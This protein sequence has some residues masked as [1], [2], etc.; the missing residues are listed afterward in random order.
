MWLRDVGPHGFVSRL[1]MDGAAVWLLDLTVVILSTE[2]WP[3]DVQTRPG[4]HP[5]GN[6]VRMR[7]RASEFWFDIAPEGLATFLLTTRS[8]PCAFFGYRQRAGHSVV[9]VTAG[10]GGRHVLGALPRAIKIQFP[11]CVP[12]V[13]FT[14]APR[15]SESCD[16]VVRLQ[17]PEGGVL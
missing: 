8:L 7:R 9:V 17:G 4:Q 12:C 16:E 3:T 11:R 1:G 2:P 14:A 10:V 15:V 6:G 13:A 5:T